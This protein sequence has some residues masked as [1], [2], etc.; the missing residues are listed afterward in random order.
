MRP[1]PRLMANGQPFVPK[2]S[3][4]CGTIVPEEG[5]ECVACYRKSLWEFFGRA[6]PVTT[7]SLSME[8]SQ[9]FPRFK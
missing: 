8:I 4:G 9:L 7:P 3:A 2:C 5:H 1:A 6:M